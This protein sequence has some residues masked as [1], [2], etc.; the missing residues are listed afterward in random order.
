MAFN[1]AGVFSRL[2]F[3]AQDAANNIN[4][5]SSRMDQ[6]MDGFAT[7]LSNVIC[8]D[9]QTSP[10]ANLPL[11]GFRFLNVANAQNRNE[12]ASVAQIQDGSLLWAGAAG[13]TANALTVSLSP[14]ISAYAIGM[15]ISAIVG[16]T[17][18]G[19]ATLSPNGLPAKN[20][21]L[22]GAPLAGGEMR[23]GQA[24]D[25]VYDGTRFQIDTG[26]VRSRFRVFKAAN[27]NISALT[28]T[29]VLFTAVGL[30]I[31]AFF[32]PANS[33]YTPPPGPVGIKASVGYDT[34]T[35][36]PVRVI[37]AI[38]K[39]GALLTSAPID[40]GMDDVFAAPVSTEDINVGGSYYE[41]YVYSTVALSLLG[42]QNDLSYFYGGAI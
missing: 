7:A 26:R 8:K 31:G 28:W 42:A 16:L 22:G 9:G 21:W 41:M 32:D 1:G 11:N 15:R 20:I 18:T 3:W 36:A 38:Y 24:L 40:H 35:T 19:P 12:Y 23:A 30:D 5:L 29:K 13:G 33:R 39:D 25:F 10:I 27:Q 14:P 37:A 4:I 2:Y 6:E 34:N 17:N